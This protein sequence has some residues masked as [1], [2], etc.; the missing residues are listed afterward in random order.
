[1]PT[2][3][4]IA[5]AALLCALCPTAAF[6]DVTAFIGANT[7]PANRQVRGA[8]GGIS[9]LIVAFEFEYAFTP[10][11]PTVSAPSLKTGMGNVLLQTP[12]PVAGFQPYVTAGGGIYNESLGA[13]SDTNFGSNAGG[14]LKLT[15]IGPLRLRVDY[16]V[17]KLG[18]GALNS[19]AHRIYAGLNL[20]F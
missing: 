14:G 11:D 20:N 19:P 6:A 1:M 17:F 5:L 18:S 9:L 7:T 10:D 12:F 8:A 2:T 16:R 4:I 13:H 15:L 3:R